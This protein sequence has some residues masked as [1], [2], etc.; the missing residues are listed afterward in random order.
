D[1]S[2]VLLSPEEQSAFMKLTVFCGGCTD[3]AA[4]QVT[5]TSLFTLSALVDK[6]FVRKTESGRYAIHELLR[7][8]GMEYLETSGQGDLASS[9]HAD[10]YLNAL[11]E[12]E[13]EIK[14]NRQ[15][16]ALDEIERDFE[17]IYAA[18]KWT[19][20]QKRFSLISHAL[21]SLYWF[22]ISRNRLQEGANLV[23][24]AI[25]QLPE[26]YDV[27]E[28][29]LRSRLLACQVAMSSLGYIQ[30]ENAPAQLEE[31]LA[32]AQDHGD[33]AGIAFCMM[34][35]GEIAL[36][37]REYRVSLSFYRQAL[38][39]YQQRGDRFYM[40]RILERI[41]FASMLS[42]NA[43]VGIETARHALSLSRETGD[44]VGAANCLYFLGGAFG[45]VGNYVEYKAAYREALAIRRETREQAGIAL[46]LGGLAHAEF[47]AGN[48][49]EALAFASEAFAI[50]SRLN[51][52]EGKCQALNWLGHLACMEENYDESLQ[53]FEDSRLIATDPYK[54]ASAELGLAMVACAHRDYSRARVHTENALELLVFRPHY[55]IFHCLLVMDLLLFSEGQTTRGLELLSLLADQPD[56][57]VGFIQKWPLISR[58]QAELRTTLGD[59][60]YAYTWKRGKTL[61]LNSLTTE[62]F[63]YFSSE[64]ENV[65]QSTSPINL[66]SMWLANQVLTV[67]LTEREHEILAL[68]AQGLSNQQIAEQLFIAVS[69]VKRHINNCYGKLS[70]TSRS[71]AI[72]KAQQLQLV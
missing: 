3:D 13:A 1:H 22:C 66:E 62:L 18:W 26:A 30:D 60:V 7:Q 61:D 2:W 55:A 27:V 40:V 57:V 52:L 9:R 50:S 36:K 65:S 16:A 64:H 23:R 58:L 72:L 35:S 71:Q 49:A 21:E 34:V 33:L 41:C 67:P 11:A 15:L 29:H 45:A 43:E 39:Y 44:R 70:V 53:L 6:S 4:R 51:Y 8:F 54:A 17:N 24:S 63:E 68:I 69:T 12:R 46:N 37:A 38:T 19:I 47:F 32:I 14:G 56:Q 10:Y 48:F 59:D 42:G 31:S 25:K 5:E 20:E 28:A